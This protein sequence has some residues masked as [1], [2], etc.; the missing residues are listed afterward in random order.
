MSVVRGERTT[1][2]IAR[3]KEL[4]ARKSIEKY[5]RSRCA[6][7]TSVA[8][9]IFLFG[10]AAFGRGFDTQSGQPIEVNLYI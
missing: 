5:A 7:T 9:I 8:I 4:L 3:G 2:V 10:T 1:F 6:A